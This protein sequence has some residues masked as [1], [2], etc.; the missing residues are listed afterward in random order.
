M[1]EKACKEHCWHG[2]GTVLTCDPPIQI[3]VCC[4]CGEEQSIRKNILPDII[5]HGRFHPD[6]IYVSYEPAQLLTGN[7]AESDNATT[8]IGNLTNYSTQTN[9]DK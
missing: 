9:E 3:Q 6:K 1:R 5:N 7:I 2:T 8:S 4:H